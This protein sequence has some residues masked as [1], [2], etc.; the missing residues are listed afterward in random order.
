MN[1]LDRMRGADGPTDLSKDIEAY[2]NSKLIGVTV[3]IERQAIDIFHNEIRKSIG[4]GTAADEK[5][6]VGMAQFCE[7]LTLITKALEDQVG[8]HPALYELKRDRLVKLS[9]NSRRAIDSPHP[10]AP[11]LLLEPVYTDAASDQRVRTKGF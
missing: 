1:D 10:S 2:S 9:V 11:D 4:R 7:D 6:D 5:C 3:R 8:V